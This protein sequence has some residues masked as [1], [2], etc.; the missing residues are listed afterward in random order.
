MG[1]VV[2]I[3]AKSE[4]PP[5]IIGHR[6]SFYTDE[7]IDL[8]LIALNTYAWDKVRYT[9]DNM[10]QLEPLFIKSCL[11]KL[12]NSGLLSYKARTVINSIL[13]NMKE[14]SEDEYYAQKI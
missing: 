2:D 10:G 4:T 1:K 14:I 8:T 6:I 9:T 5:K 7:E 11:I 13:N 3:T 12:L